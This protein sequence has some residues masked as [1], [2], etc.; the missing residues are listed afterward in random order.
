MMGSNN[1]SSLYIVYIESRIEVSIDI[2]DI[3]NISL[4][5]IL[6]IILEFSVWKLSEEFMG[7]SSIFYSSWIYPF[8]SISIQILSISSIY[9]FDPWIYKYYDNISMIIF[10]ISGI[11][12]I[13]ILNY[14]R[15]LFQWIWYGDRSY[16]IFQW[17]NRIWSMRI[18]NHISIRINYH[19]LK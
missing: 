3:F 15:I 4:L 8:L 13:S 17:I 6:I 5:Y 10:V 12:L 11:Y 18:S 1:L 9:S 7:I 14:I 19:F 2:I 16:Y